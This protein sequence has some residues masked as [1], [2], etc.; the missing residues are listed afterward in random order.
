MPEFYAAIFGN[1]EDAAGPP[2]AAATKEGDGALGATGRDVG[3]ASGVSVSGDGCGGGVLFVAGRAAEAAAAT[4]VNTARLGGDDVGGE[5]AAPAATL[6]QHQDVATGA[7]A[8]PEEVKG[9]ALQERLVRL[10][11]AFAKEQ[12]SAVLNNATGW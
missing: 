11:E 10:R 5:V 2:S 7:D 1:G 4:T 8:R 9:I 3:V 6:Q 12:C